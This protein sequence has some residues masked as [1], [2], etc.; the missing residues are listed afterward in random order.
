[1]IA[2]PTYGAH[3]AQV[4]MRLIL[5]GKSVSIT[6]MGSDFVIVETAVKHPPCEA[7]ILL[8]VDNAER[9]WTVRLPKG[10]SAESKRVEITSSE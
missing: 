3:S 4:D 5:T 1:M 6:H 8:Q 7:T 2:E 9:R 10:I